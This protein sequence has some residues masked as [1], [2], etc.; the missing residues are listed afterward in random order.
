[1]HDLVL[2]K[3]AAGRDQDLVFNRELVRHGVV[4][5]RKLTHLVP[6]LPIEEDRKRV[7]HDRIKRDFAAA[8]SRSGPG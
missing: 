3:Y 5:K 6:S 2:S 1:M 8:G 4:S 7:I